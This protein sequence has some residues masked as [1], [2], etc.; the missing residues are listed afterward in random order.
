FI[1]CEDWRV[2]ML[3]RIARR[4]SRGSAITAAAAAG[5][6]ILAS[7]S[8]PLGA[9]APVPQTTHP[10]K[11]GVIGSG[12]QGGN[13]GLGGAEAGQQVLF[14]SR[15]AEELKQL[16]AKAGAK[17]HAGFPEDA[18]KFGDVVLIAVPY[19]SLPQVG[20]DYAPLMKGKV[21]IELGNPRE[22]RDGPMANDA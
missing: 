7:R 3:M 21:V 22:D 12:A 4:S 18:A 11:I 15:H 9:Q 14:S 8:V 19:G 13:L 17:A 5:L 1:R 6:L 2:G 20:R 10:R 16:V